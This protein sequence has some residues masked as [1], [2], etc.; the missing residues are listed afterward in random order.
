MLCTLFNYGI[1][2]DDSKFP[3]FT[4]LPQLNIVHYLCCCYHFCVWN[5]MVLILKN[6]KMSSGVNEQGIQGKL[7]DWGADRRSILNG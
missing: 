1:Q 2:G 5:W 3:E 4:L 7:F 6:K